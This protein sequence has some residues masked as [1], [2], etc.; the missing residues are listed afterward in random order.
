MLFTPL[1]LAVLPLLLSGSFLGNN[2]VGM[3][4]L[5]SGILLVSGFLHQHNE[6]RLLLNTKWLVWTLQLLFLLIF[7]GIN[8]LYPAITGKNTKT[9]FSDALLA[10]KV[11]ALWQQ[12]QSEPLTILIANTSTGG[13]VLLY[14]RPEPL[15]L[16]HN[17]PVIAPWVNRQDVA[18]CGAF[19]LVEKHEANLPEYV[20]L[21][22]QATLKGTFL[23]PWGH[24]NPKMMVQYAWAIIS[25][26]VNQ[27]ECRFK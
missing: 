6:A 19:V 10:E 21:F 11:A 13:N 22:Q 26:E 27:P 15:L 14:A 12:H 3:F 25:P 5:P 23:L 20:S 4:F 17:N 2:W 9:N 1:V 18:S 8:Q 16:I 7:L 24:A